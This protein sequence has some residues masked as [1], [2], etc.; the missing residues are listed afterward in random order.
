MKLNWINDYYQWL[1]I[2]A[3]NDKE[4]SEANTGSSHIA[5]DFQ[6][7][8]TSALYQAS[9][10]NTRSSVYAQTLP[11][12][13][14]TGSSLVNHVSAPPLNT[15][16]GD[17]SSLIEEA[18]NK[19]KVD[20]DLIY[21][22]I[23]NESNFNPFAESSAGAQG[24]MQLMPGTARGLGVTNSFDARQNIDGGTRYLKEM[25]DRYKGNTSLALAAYNAGPGNVDRYGG[26][27]PFKE[28]ENYV[29][30]VL[31]TYESIKNNSSPFN[32]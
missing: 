10:L 29:P 28:T 17:Y 1:A 11:L 32:L 24:L 25:L 18:A 6:S 26:I 30:K 20:K 23:K 3:I 5:K 16:S 7:Y 22:V 19:Y 12:S 4:S 9:S 31:A 8:L 21:A 2:R 13:H 15:S 27:P 14:L